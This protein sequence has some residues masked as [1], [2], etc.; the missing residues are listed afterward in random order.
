MYEGFEQDLMSLPRDSLM[1]LLQSI[2]DVT[3]KR[4]LSEEF[5]NYFTECLA[6]HPI[7]FATPSESVTIPSADD[8]AANDAQLS[9]FL[10]LQQDLHCLPK[11][12]LKIVLRFIAV[13]IKE[14]KL[15]GEF[16]EFPISSASG[17]VAI[18]RPFVGAGASD[19]TP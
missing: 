9:V 1:N 13:A 4:S 19:V 11:E 16:L 17:S 18:T 3:H 15:D 10:F 8:A 5:S 6:K 12:R 7:S 14:R 2:A